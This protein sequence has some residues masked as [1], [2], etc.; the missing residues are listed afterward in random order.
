MSGGGWLDSDDF[1]S[2]R[3]GTL[4]L[5]SEAGQVSGIAG[6][7]ND[8]PRLRE[9]DDGEERVQSAPVPGQ[10]GPPEQLTGRTALVFVDRSYCRPAKHLVHTSIP[11]FATQDLSKS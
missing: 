8:G 7:Q 2:F 4:G 10:P 9:R 3:P 1:N 11:A 5:L 6:E